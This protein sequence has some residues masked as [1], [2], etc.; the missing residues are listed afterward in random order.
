MK[1][2]RVKFRASSPQWT[3]A[4][5]GA[6][7]GFKLAGGHPVL[8]VKEIVNVPVDVATGT[9]IATMNRA[10]FVAPFAAPFV[11]EWEELLIPGV[12]IRPEK[13]RNVTL[14]VRFPQSLHAALVT[15]ASESERSLNAEIIRACR[16]HVTAT[17]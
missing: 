7:L 10:T 12:I 6:K 2:V 9:A 3:A 1:T 17:G 16:H 13:E 15:A 4:N 14:N 5:P 8:V 11:V